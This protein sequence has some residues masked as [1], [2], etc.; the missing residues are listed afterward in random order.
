MPHGLRSNIRRCCTLT[1]VP[2]LLAFA[3]A[4]TVSCADSSSGTGPADGTAPPAEAALLGSF[5]YYTGSASLEERIAGADVIAKVRLRSVSSGAEFREIVKDG[6]LKHIG[7]L[8]HRFEVLEYLKGTGDGELLAVVNEL[9]DQETAERAAEAGAAL[10]ARRDARW[11]SRE[12]IV[13][14]WDGI[15][16]KD[17]YILGSV[18]TEYGYFGDYYTI[19]SFRH[20]RWLPA[21]SDGGRESGVSGRFLLDARADAGAGGTYRQSGS[22]PTITLAAMKA[23]IA[24]IE[25]EAVAGDGSEAYRDCLYEKYKWEREVSYFKE[26]KDGDYFYK[27][28]DQA[29]ASGLPAETQVYTAIQAGYMLQKHGE[30]EPRGY[31]E[32]VLR[33]RDE[34]LFHARWPGVAK[35]ARPL[36]DGEYKFYYSYRPQEYVI[37]DAHPEEEMKRHEVFVT[38]TAPAG[39][40]HEAFFDPVTVGTAVGADGSNG[41]L[42]PVEFT[43]GGTATTMQDLKWENGSVVLTLSPYTA[44]TGVAIDFIALD[45]SVTFSLHSKDAT[46]DSAAGTLTWA[47]ESAPWQAGDKLMLR[48]REGVAAP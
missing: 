27:R 15:R 43:V 38:V 9:V 21:A 45:G 28:H 6:D 41:V 3:L 48:I 44:L 31:G 2:F 17:R 26:G 10:L 40:V 11:D 47:V 36:P 16:Q 4:L 35:T 32:F 20:Q 7:A 18:T 22:V 1:G 13:F 8:E 24:E 29:T 46:A 37:C 5:L 30:T 23:K 39:T 42:K 33:G 25:R 14:L 34:D 19:A 12:A